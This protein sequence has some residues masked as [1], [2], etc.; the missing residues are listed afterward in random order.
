MAAAMIQQPLHNDL[1]ACAINGRDRAAM[2]ADRRCDAVID[3]RVGRRSVHRQRSQHH[4]PRGETGGVETTT[5]QGRET[6]GE[7]AG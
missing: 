6:G 5:Q 3:Y 2:V 4:V 1:A 7:H